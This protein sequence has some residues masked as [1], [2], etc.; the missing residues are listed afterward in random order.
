MLE[1][2]GFDAAAYWAHREFKKFVVSMESGPRRKPQRETRYVCARTSERA[3]VCAKAQ[4]F[5]SSPR[6]VDIRLAT[7]RDLGCIVSPVP[8][9]SIGSPE[10]IAGLLRGKATA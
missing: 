4:S 3:E 10:H 2:N 1:V 9:A 8:L 7:P 5:M 6:V